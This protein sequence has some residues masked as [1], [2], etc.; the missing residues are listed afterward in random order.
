M[1]EGV[2]L[3]SILINILGRNSRTWKKR[4]DLLL[5]WAEPHER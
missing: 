5:V 3:C 1:F 2:F 4:G